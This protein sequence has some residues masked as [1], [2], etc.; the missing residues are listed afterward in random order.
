MLVALVLGTLS[1]A[2]PPRPAAPKVIGPRDTT[3]ERPVYAFQSRGA[4]GFRC[5]FDTTVLHRCS[6]RYSQGIQP[7]R[8]V[9]RVRAV[10]RR[11]TLSRV[12][13][14]RVLVRF[15]VP[16]LIADWTVSVGAGA[17]V[18]ATFASAAYVPVTSDGTVAVVRDGAVASRTTVGVPATLNG[19]LDAAV[20]DG[21]P[22]TQRSIWV[23]S[24]EGARITRVDPGDGTARFDVAPRPGGLTAT[25]RAVWAFHFLQG[26]ITR[27][28]IPTMTAKR[29]EVAGAQATGIAAYGGSLWLLTVRPSRVVE[30]DPDTGAVKR[31]INLVPPFALRRS[32]IE[33]WWL[34]AA[35][36]ALW[37][38]LPN[39]GAVARVDATTG[40]V[41]YIRIPYGEP[42]GVAAAAGTAWVATDRAVL[43]LNE[44]TGALQAAVLVPRADR[45]GFV[46]I[47]Y[48]YG[49]A[50]FTNYDRGTLTRLRAPGTPP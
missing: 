33:T 37:A 20:D 5:S 34:S 35:D 23:T 46:S 41:Q 31:T 15:P 4:V 43:Q 18:P 6:R 49:A 42:F 32:L 45:T 48:G 25:E 2:A 17:G 19:L 26:T 28:D 16:A 27:I 22:S 9:L 12:V 14:V 30:L 21:R 8:H 1:L 7:G 44:T 10:G 24:D 29:L 39:H 40:A 11:G 50:W 3:L 36:G 47:A 13:A 38:T